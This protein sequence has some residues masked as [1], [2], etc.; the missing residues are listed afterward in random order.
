MLDTITRDW[1]D[2]QQDRQELTETVSCLS[3]FIAQ[4]S[5]LSDLQAQRLALAILEN[6]PESG[7]VSAARAT[8]LL[9]CA[10][11]NL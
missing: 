6:G 8:R 2:Q 11:S 4:H 7:V 3:S 5:A 1:F 9:E 10:D